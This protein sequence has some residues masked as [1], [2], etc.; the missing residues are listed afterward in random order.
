MCSHRILC[1]LRLNEE[2][3]KTTKG[4]PKRIK[5]TS[6]PS[7]KIVLKRIRQ[8]LEEAGMSFSFPL[9]VA[10]VREVEKLVDAWNNHQTQRELQ[11]LV[12]GFC[13]LQKLKD[14]SRVMDAIPDCPT[15]PQSSKWSF[16]NIIDKVARYRE[17]ARFLTRLAKK[18]SLVRDMR[19]VLVR[20]PPEVFRRTPVGQQLDSN[21]ASKALQVKSKKVK[22]GVIENMCR[23]LGYTAIPEANQAHVKKTRKTLKEAKVHAEIQLLFY[24]E[25]MEKSELPPRVVCS[26]KDA[27]FLC[28]KFILRHGKMH[29]PRSHG[30]LYP[31][32][33]LPHA[34]NTDLHSKFVEYLDSIIKDSISTLFSRETMTN[35]PNPNESTLLTLPVSTSTLSSRRTRQSATQSERNW[36]QQ[37]PPANAVEGVAVEPCNLEPPRV[38]S[39]SPHSNEKLATLATTTETSKL[40][41]VSDKRLNNN[42]SS[43]SPLPEMMSSVAVED[44]AQTPD[45]VQLTETVGANRTSPFYSNG[46]LDVLVEYSPDA[47]SPSGLSKQL[48]FSVEWLG[49]A[50]AEN[51]RETQVQHVF[52]A[53]KMETEISLSL[54]DQNSVYISAKGSLAKLTFGRPQGS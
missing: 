17:C 19:V 23:L 52:E 36:Q 11:A 6:K 22:G 8:L 35:Y 5:N 50:D 13:R 12:E 2:P 41:K 9:F 4:A 39:G 30:R 42:A 15:F 18:C 49:A 54:N 53:D 29:T 37:P 38:P 48:P 10:T 43:I 25:E 3:V 7:I 45:S 14:A 16:L 51:V 46:V 20:L 32:W 44:D 27:C 1:R 28:N 21:L 40:P 47:A 31:G 24:R 34:G 33:R 26:S